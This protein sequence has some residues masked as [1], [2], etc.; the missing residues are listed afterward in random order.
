MKKWKVNNKVYIFI[1]FFREC[2]NLWSLVLRTSQVLQ[3]KTVKDTTGS[4]CNY[5]SAHE[6]QL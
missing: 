1:L 4:M 2:Q 5:L 6:E 3:F